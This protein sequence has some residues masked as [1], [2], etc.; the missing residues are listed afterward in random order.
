MRPFSPALFTDL[1][2]LTMAQA[3]FEEGMSDEGHLQPL[4][5]P[6]PQTAKLPGRL[7]IG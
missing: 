5:A 7:R 3:D 6:T 2:E 1:Y 4:R